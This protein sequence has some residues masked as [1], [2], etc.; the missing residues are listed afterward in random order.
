MAAFVEDELQS[1]RA[2]GGV[3]GR[4]IN[5]GIGIDR[6]AGD[7]RIA[8]NV[9]WSRSGVDESD[10]AAQ[11]F[12]RDEEVE[13]TDVSLVLAADRSFAKRGRSGCSPFTIPLNRLPSCV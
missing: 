4:S 7:Y 2:L 3:P 9:L 12:A 10:P 13:R 1:F 5:G 11:S 8:A 6:R